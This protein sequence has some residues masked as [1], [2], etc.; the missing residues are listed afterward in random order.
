MRGLGRGIPAVALALVCLAGC[1]GSTGNKGGMPVPE[2]GGSSSGT[3]ATTPTPTA[4][5]SS[6]RPTTAP[7]KTAAPPAAQVTVV[8]GNQAANPA[9]QGFVA[10]Y[11]LYFQALVQR[12]PDIVKKNF[13]AFFYADTAV[14]IDNAKQSGWVMRPPGSVVV[15]GVEQRPYGVVRLKVCRSQTTQYWNPKSGKWVVV[16]PKGTAEATDM[17]RTGLGWTMYRAVRPTPKGINCSK[18]RYP[19]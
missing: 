11:P 16:A 14:N 4:G 6:G 8:P 2:G 15:V 18:V 3:T 10:K 13:P 1:G 7:P 17:V 12:N 9:V 19:A 5:K